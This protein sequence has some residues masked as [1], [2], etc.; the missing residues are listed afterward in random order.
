MKTH[1][2]NKWK[3]V[4]SN[5]I[6]GKTLKHGIALTGI[7]E[8]GQRTRSRR[9]TSVDDQTF[10]DAAGDIYELCKPATSTYSDDISAPLRK[11]I[12]LVQE[13]MAERNA[14]TPLVDAIAMIENLSKAN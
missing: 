12:E 10:T 11:V 5:N 4:P 9:I 6:D 3:T 1:H 8:K 2:L 14:R 7:N 13:Q